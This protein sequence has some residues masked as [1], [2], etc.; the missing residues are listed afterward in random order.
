MLKYFLYCNSFLNV[1]MKGNEVVEVTFI[2]V[3]LALVR[4]ARATK[5]EPAVA[6]YRFVTNYGKSIKKY[7]MEITGIEPMSHACRAHVL[8]LNYIP[9]FKRA[10]MFL[11][12][13]F[14]PLINAIIS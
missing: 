5:K 2:E 7:N 14:I 9:L 10:Y 8:P 11:A 6:F 12:I 3:S 13:V 1:I 4:K